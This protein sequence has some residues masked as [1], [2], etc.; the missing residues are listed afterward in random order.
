MRKSCHTDSFIKQRVSE[1]L[2]EYLREHPKESYRTL[3]KKLGVDKSVVSRYISCSNL[4]AITTLVEIAR[5][6][7][8]SLDYVCGV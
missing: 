7:G 5:L 3:G 1:V 8:V 4:P 2:I 6:C